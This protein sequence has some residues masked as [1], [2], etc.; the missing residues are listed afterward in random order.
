MEISSDGRVMSRDS[1]FSYECRICCRC[2][3]GKGIQVNPY[4][5]MRL[6]ECLGISTSDFREK[7]L[8]NQFLRHKDNSDA[9]VFLDITGC[10]VHRDRP[11]VCRLYPLGRARLENGEEIFFKVNPH[12]DSEGIYGQASTVGHYLLSQNVEPFIRAEKEYLELL[13]KMA[14]AALDVEETEHSGNTITIAEFDDSKWI[15]DP[16]PVIFRFCQLKDLNFPSTAED[17]LEFHLNALYAWTEGEWN[18]MT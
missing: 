15:L 13:K 4:E 12:P 5:T 8:I 1:D 2:C 14:G 11:L 6:A 18:P 16:D 10:M 7:Y 9:C 17:K 3:H